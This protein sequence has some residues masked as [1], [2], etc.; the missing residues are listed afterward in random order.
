MAI[1][2]LDDAAVCGQGIVYECLDVEPAGYRTGG[3]I[4]L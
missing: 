1:L 4:H 3:T 2:I